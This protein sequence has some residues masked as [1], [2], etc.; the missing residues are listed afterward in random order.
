MN[1]VDLVK[2]NNFDNFLFVNLGFF[3]EVFVLGLL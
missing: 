3:D 2:M 1:E